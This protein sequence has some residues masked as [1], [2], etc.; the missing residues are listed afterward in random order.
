MVLLMCVVVV[1]EVLVRLLVVS[2]VEV[3]RW[4]CVGESRLV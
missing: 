2:F 3:I 4:C 1:V